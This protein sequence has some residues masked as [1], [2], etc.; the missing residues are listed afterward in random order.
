MTA[1]RWRLWL[2]AGIATFALAY[3]AWCKWGP[4]PAKPG[5]I[6]KA[7]T[8]PKI[9]DMERKAVTPKKLMVFTPKAEAVK[10][11]KLPPDQAGNDDE[12]LFEATEAPPNRYGL[13]TATFVNI[14]TG[15]PRTVIV[16]KKAPLF[17]FERGNRVGAEYG[18]SSKG[19]YFQGDYQRDIISVKG[20]V[21]GVRGAVISYP[22]ETDA[23]A[24]VRAE[25]R[26]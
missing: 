2:W 7:T 21:L 10:K 19:R 24:G 20:V 6:I 11:L 9:A 22:S 4:Q 8:S 15:K 13:T 14:T 3:L 18:I 16:V 12:E 23:T 25:Y 1:P 17:Q 26:W 5:A